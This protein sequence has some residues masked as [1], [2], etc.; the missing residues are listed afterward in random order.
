[1]TPGVRISSEV[2]AHENLSGSKDRLLI[3]FMDSRNDPTS[4]DKDWKDDIDRFH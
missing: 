2:T 4:V 1:M 3:R